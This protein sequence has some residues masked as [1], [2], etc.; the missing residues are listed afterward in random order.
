M[1][2]DD[3]KLAAYREA[4]RALWIAQPNTTTQARYHGFVRKPNVHCHSWIKW[5]EASIHAVPWCQDLVLKTI[6]MK[7]GLTA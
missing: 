4:L 3:P 5:V 1:T 6:E 2:G 7:L